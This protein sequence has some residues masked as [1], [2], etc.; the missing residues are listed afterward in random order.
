MII[1]LEPSL[2]GL[3]ERRFLSFSRQ[4]LARQAA[5]DQDRIT[6]FVDAE[7]ALA[8]QLQDL[9]GQ[10]DEYTACVRVLGD[11]ARLRWTLVESGHGL[12]LHSPRPHDAHT[13]APCEVRRRKDAIR[14]ELRP[15]V[16][17]QFADRHVRRFIERLE[18]PTASSR[19]RSIN[20]LIADGTEVKRV[21]CR[22]T[23]H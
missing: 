22:F 11:L 14:R 7:T 20:A 2:E 21:G 9:E 6:A 13:S 16:L 8:P 12:E 3:A 1:P 18:R 5:R 15:R 17:Q 19:H 4:V 23:A 10:R